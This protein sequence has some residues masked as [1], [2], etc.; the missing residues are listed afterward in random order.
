VLVIAVPVGLGHPTLVGQVAG[1]AVVRVALAGI[2]ASRTSAGDRAGEAVGG[3]VR[4]RLGL[5]TAGVVIPDG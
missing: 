2:G 5:G 1:G 3:V 4:E